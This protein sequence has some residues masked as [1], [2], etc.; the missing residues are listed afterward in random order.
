MSRIK[1]LREEQGWTQAE[2]AKRSGL[3]QPTIARLETGARG[4]TEQKLQAVAAALGVSREDLDVPVSRR[5]SGTRVEKPSD[6]NEQAAQLAKVEARRARAAFLARQVVFRSVQLKAETA[7]GAWREN[8]ELPEDQWRVV[9]SVAMGERV[10]REAEIFAVAL[11]GRLLDEVLPSGALLICAKVAQ[12][13]GI[14]PRTGDIVI[15]HRRREGDLWEV[16][17]RQIEIPTEGPPLLRFRSPV[18]ARLP[19][20]AAGDDVIVAAVVLQAIIELWP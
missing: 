12:E 8:V 16:T 9:A 15:V 17:A 6:S 20:I 2:L 3:T 10:P 18:T 19:P 13:L 14:V 11:R 4:T 7:A 5:R 1:R